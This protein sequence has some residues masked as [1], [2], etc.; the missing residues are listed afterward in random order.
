MNDRI[1]FVCVCVCICIQTLYT[2]TACVC[3]C[4]CICICIC[5]HMYIY[6][7]T[8]THRPCICIMHIHV[9]VHM[10]IESVTHL[11][12]Q[13]R[14]KL[15]AG[16]STCITHTCTSE[17]DTRKPASARAS[18]NRRTVTVVL[19]RTVM[20]NRAAPTLLSRRCKV[21]T[22]IFFFG[23]RYQEQLCSMPLCKE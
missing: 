11:T 8:H 23:A 16:R 21:C 13:F 18:T 1:C 14:A 2:Y 12:H 15:G 10:Y 6:A 4:I 3:I 9:Y 22:W 20:R 19:A 17:H 5:M 7:N